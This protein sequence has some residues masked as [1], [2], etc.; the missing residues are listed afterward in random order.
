[1]KEHQHHSYVPGSG[2]FG[3]Y[4][5]VLL[6]ALLVT[7]ALFWQLR[8]AQLAE[9]RSQ[10]E[11][12]AAAYTALVRQETD[13]SLLALKSLGWFIDGTGT[14]DARSFQAF[15]AACLPERKELKA[16]SWN[17]RVTDSERADFEQKARQEGVN[18]F[19]I[20]ER[21]PDGSPVTARAREAH[22]PVFYIEPLQRNET[23]VGFD[24]GSEPVRRAAL[25]RAR[26][27]GEPAVTE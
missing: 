4:A 18:Q 6:I 14:L 1:M 16:L 11:S 9:F 5:I 24:V 2:S 7:A 25:E 26:D 15:A 19:R 22:Y 20:T 8:R 21:S 13:K 3:R 27:T 23:A 10:F 17:P 12:D